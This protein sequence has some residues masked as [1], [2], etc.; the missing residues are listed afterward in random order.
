MIPATNAPTCAPS[1]DVCCPTPLLP[2]PTP[3]DH[4]ST[5]A[6]GV[7]EPKGLRR[8]R[9]G[10][11]APMTVTPE[12]DDAEADY[13]LNVLFEPL[14]T[15]LGASLHVVC[16]QDSNGARVESLLTVSNIDR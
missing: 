8:R 6:R 13:M 1:P 11:S 14:N 15:P 2:P 12:T 5:R 16:A 4:A 10:A 3:E 7:V 9:T